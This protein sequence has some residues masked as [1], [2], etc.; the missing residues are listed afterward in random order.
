MLFVTTVLIN[1]NIQPHSN[2]HPFLVKETYK[3][4]SDHYEVSEVGVQNWNTKDSPIRYRE[5]VGDEGAG[6]W[7]QRDN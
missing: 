7:L 6:K 4:E 5:S 1:K 3:Q 2:K